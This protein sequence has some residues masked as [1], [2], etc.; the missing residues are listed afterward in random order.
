MPKFCANLS[1]MF[2]EYPFLDRFKAASDAG[3]KGIEYLFP[4]D[5]EPAEI[6]KR[7]TEY[8]LT[9]VLFNAPPGD[10][11]AGERGMAAIPGRMPEFRESIEDAMEFVEAL[12]PTR[13]HIMAGN[14]AGKGAQAMYMENLDWASRRAGDQVILIEPINTRDMPSYFLNRTDQAIGIIEAIGAPNLQLQLD[15]YHTQITEGDLT[16]RMER[17][18]GYIGHV[19][20]AGVPDRHEP[21]EGELNIHHLLDVLDALGYEGWVGCEYHP[22][23]KTEDGLD[24]L[25]EFEQ[26]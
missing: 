7:L 20:I 1:M 21:D 17:L 3:F 26:G 14:A 22:A 24:W 23:G 18:I 25:K 6:Q 13:L 12:H 4:Y 2:T 11:D 10:W 9:Q 16:R 15:L 19:Q 8:G 5:F